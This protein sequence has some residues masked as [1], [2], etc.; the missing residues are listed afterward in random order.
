MNRCMLTL[1][2]V[3]M[4]VCK[5]SKVL[6]WHMSGG[7]SPSPSPLCAMWPW[8]A[9]TSTS[10]HALSLCSTKC[11]IKQLRS[12]QKGQESASIPSPL[13]WSCSEFESTECPKSVLL[14]HPP[15]ILQYVQDMPISRADVS[16]TGTKLCETYLCHQYWAKF[17]LGPVFR[18]GLGP[19]VA[20][21][22]LK[23]HFAT[24]QLSIC[25]LCF[26]LQTSLALGTWNWETL[27]GAVPSSFL[28][29]CGNICRN[30]TSTVPVLFQSFFL[31]KVEQAW[32]V[33]VGI[34]PITMNTLR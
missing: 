14:H 1:E 5:G 34:G 8:P 23:C 29:F 19:S 13:H 9:L 28:Y 3:K 7:P 4:Q 25:S 22:A 11:K 31:S 32:E 20:Q 10:R 15:H 30:S 27:G 21:P 2:V 17:G 26:Y 18:G 12:K 16:I 24:I 6:L 33:H